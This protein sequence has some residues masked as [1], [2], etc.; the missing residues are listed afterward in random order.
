M[1]RKKEPRGCDPAGLD[2]SDPAKG[3]FAM[4]PRHPVVV[5]IKVSRLAG[6]DGR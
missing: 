5:S 2:S 6:T 4:L 3:A 1:I